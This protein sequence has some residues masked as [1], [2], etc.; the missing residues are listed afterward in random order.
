MTWTKEGLAC[1]GNTRR[2]VVG[3]LGVNEE[4]KAVNSTAVKPEGIGQEEDTEMLDA[5]E[6]KKIQTFGGDVE[7]HERQVGRAIRCEGG[8]HEDGESHTRQLEE[9]ERKNVEDGCMAQIEE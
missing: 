2:R 5:P 3:R 1:E 6:T 8:V 7:Q 9:A 4:S